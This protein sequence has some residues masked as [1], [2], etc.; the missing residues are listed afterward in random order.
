MK[1]IIKSLYRLI[2]YLIKA[3]EKFY[4]RYYLKIMSVSIGVNY[5]IKGIPYIRNEGKITI[6]A[7]FRANSGKN[8]NPIGGD[9]ILRVITK[10]G[11]QLNIGNNV[12]ISNST[13]FCTQKIVI[14]DSVL[15]GGGCRIWDTDFH[16]ID[17]IIRANKEDE[18]ISKPIIIKKNAFIGGGSVILKGVTIGENSIIATGSVLTKIVPKNQ[19]WGGNPAKFIRNL[20]N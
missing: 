8:N 13:L 9:T 12:G 19:L 5:S 2:H 10:P 18:G 11:A 3:L 14:E 1:V 20:N 6:G 17:P 7:N 15:I 16:S 4:L